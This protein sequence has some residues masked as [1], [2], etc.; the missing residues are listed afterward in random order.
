MKNTGNIYS[1]IGRIL[2]S[3][4]FLLQCIIYFAYNKELIPDVTECIGSSSFW[5]IV[6]AI[7]W[8]LTAVCLLFNI[9]TR[10]VGVFATAVIIII[11]GLSTY[12]G[13]T[14][15]KTFV[16]TELSF[17]FYASI[18]GG[19]LMVAARGHYW[20]SGR[21][22][23]LPDSYYLFWVGRILTGL[24]FVTAGWLHFAHTLSDAEMISGMPH[25]ISMF[26]V[27]FLGICWICVA[28][29]FWFNILSRLSAM[30]ATVAI[31]I[32]TFMINIKMFGHG[33]DLA[34]WIQISRNVGL[35]A[36]C[37][38]VASKGYFKIKG[39]ERQYSRY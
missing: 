10:T 35:I 31:I 28:I 21:N 27:I 37:W 19:L 4:C 36:A 25:G 30:L 3:V 15:D 38:L 12:T 17:A 23:K 22:S 34:A 2:L 24:F 6:L 32:I 13:L 5:V 26:F 29:S 14:T 16:I 11:L 18:M 7:I 20:V 8:G 39:K 9:I 33:N 1:T